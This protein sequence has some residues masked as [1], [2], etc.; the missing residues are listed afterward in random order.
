MRGVRLQQG[1]L[2]TVKLS[3][4]PLVLLALSY[5]LLPG[6][7]TAQTPAPAGTYVLVSAGAQ[8]LPAIGSRILPYEG[9][10]LHSSRL[11]LTKGGTLQGQVVVSFTD[12]STVVD[13]ILVKGSWE[14]DRDTVRLTYQYSQ[15]RWQGG[16]R[17]Y[18]SDRSVAGELTGYDLTLPELAGF[19]QRFFGEPTPL[20]FRRAH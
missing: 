11:E 8:Q 6:P 2:M 15:P 12:S 5:A 14:L 1:S 19:D 16:P 18:A 4:P 17:R 3:F 20:R 10:A 9:A 7:L 13:T